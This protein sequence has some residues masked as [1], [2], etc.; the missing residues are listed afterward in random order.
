[1]GQGIPSC[2]L[3]DSRRTWRLMSVA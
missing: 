1:A 2:A 3:P